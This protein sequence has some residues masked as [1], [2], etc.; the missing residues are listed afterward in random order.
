MAL[1]FVTLRNSGTN[2][3]VNTKGGCKKNKIELV[4]ESFRNVS[5]YFLYLPLYNT[6]NLSCDIKLIILFPD[7]LST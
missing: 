7:D 4:M 1:D 6:G 3:P 2:S 5:M